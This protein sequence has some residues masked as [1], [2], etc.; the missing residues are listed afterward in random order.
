[1]E[2]T[3]TNFKQC[4]ICEDTEATSFCPQ[5]FCY[6]CDDCYK[7]VHNKKKNKNHKKE[8][9]D[10]NIPIDTWCPDHKKNAISLFCLDEKGKL[11]YK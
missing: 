10:D 5:C 3:Q 1:M 7:P 2:N 8:T 6:Y 4:N 11:Y 9:I